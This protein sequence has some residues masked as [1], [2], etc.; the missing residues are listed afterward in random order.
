MF[1]SHYRRTL[2]YILEEIWS[3][4]SKEILQK[5]SEKINE[6]NSEIQEL[7]TFLKTVH[8]Y[9]KQSSGVANFQSDIEIGM[10]ALCLISL[11]ESHSRPENDEELTNKEELIFRQLLN[12]NKGGAGDNNN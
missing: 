12:G 8:Y 11:E 6:Y 1:K 4:D 3:S 2:K 9:R 7:I 5:Y 10:I